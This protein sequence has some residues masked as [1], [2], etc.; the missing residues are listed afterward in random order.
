MSNGR[1]Y[2]L[3]ERD[4]LQE[5][6]MTGAPVIPIS[7][8]EFLN[9]LDTR[10]ANKKLDL[11][12]R[13]V[14]DL[15]LSGKDLS[16]IDF[17]CTRFERVD[18]D[19]A[20]MDGCDV[21][22]CFFVDSSFHNVSLTN[23]DAEEASFRGIDLRG[24]DFSGTDF[25]SAGLEYSNME[26]IITD[27]KTKWLGDGVPKTGAF[28]AWK[29]GGNGRVIEMLVPA[30]AKRTCST[31]E[32]GR[33][34]YAKVLTI[35]SVDFSETYEWETALVDDDFLYEKGKMVYP[36]NGFDPYPWMSDAAGIH[37]FTDRDMAISFG[38]GYYK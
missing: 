1:F 19:G 32:A 27:E 30:E 28:L 5:M 31:T 13:W 14:S 22:R 4:Q 11:S 3:D 36:A 38:T 15:D 16:N 34:E 18:F 6:E 23:S 37:F 17:S 2:H 35:T 29:I 9:A 20:N 8:E 24:S 33:C 26:G 10:P 21:K 12:R 25:Y 7:A